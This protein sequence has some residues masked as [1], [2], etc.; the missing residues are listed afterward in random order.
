MTEL[1]KAAK[2]EIGRWATTGLRTA[3]SPSDEG[4]RQ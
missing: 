4:S 3:A 2:Q 1:E